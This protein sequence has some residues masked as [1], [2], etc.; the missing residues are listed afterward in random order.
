MLKHQT[1]RLPANQ[2]RNGIMMCICNDDMMTVWRYG[3]HSVFFTR[4]IISSKLAKILTSIFNN[5]INEI[6]DQSFGSISFITQHVKS[7]GIPPIFKT[8]GFKFMSY[9]SPLY[10][11]NVYIIISSR[12]LHKVNQDDTIGMPRKVEREL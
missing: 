4:S 11:K 5:N 12:F 9:L 10:S 6:I 7:S 2:W 8:R 3:K 1:K